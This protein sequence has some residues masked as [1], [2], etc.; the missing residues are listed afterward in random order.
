MK[1]SRIRGT[2]C[3]RFNAKVALSGSRMEDR[4]V[5][6][7]RTVTIGDK[8]FVGQSVADMLAEANKTTFAFSGFR[9]EAWFMGGKINL[10]PELESGKDADVGTG[11]GKSLHR[12]NPTDRFN[13]SQVHGICNILETE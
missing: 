2:G 11:T 9:G 10:L 7:S 1:N 6:Y 5:K 4:A 13:S 8:Y 3:R 12:P